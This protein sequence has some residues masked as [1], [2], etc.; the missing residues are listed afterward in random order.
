[1]S[2]VVALTSA[3]QPCP[4]ADFTSKRFRA[5]ILSVRG[6]PVNDTSFAAITTAL[7]AVSIQYDVY[8]LVNDMKQ[9]TYFGEFQLYDYDGIGKYSAIIMTSY[10]MTYLDQSGFVKQALTELQLA[11]IRE[12][13]QNTSTRI[14]MIGSKLGPDNIIPGV[15]PRATTSLADSAGVLAM[16]KLGRFHSIAF[17][18]KPIWTTSKTIYIGSPNDNVIPFAALLRNTRMDDD[19]AAVVYNR[20][21][22]FA[23]GELH[24][25][26]SGDELIPSLTSAAI[27]WAYKGLGVTYSAS[28]GYVGL[29]V[30]QCHGVPIGVQV[31][32]PWDC[33]LDINGSL[34]PHTSTN[35]ITVH[36][37]PQII[38]VTAITSETDPRMDM[39]ADNVYISGDH[40]TGGGDSE[41]RVALT[42]VVV[43]RD[44][45]NNE[46]F[47]EMPPPVIIDL[48]PNSNSSVLRTEIMDGFTYVDY[49]VNNPGEFVMVISVGQHVT[50][51]R[52]KTY[53]MTFTGNVSL[54]NEP[55]PNITLDETRPQ[56]VPDTT[57]NCLRSDMKILIISATGNR[58]LDPMYAV[59]VDNLKSIGINYDEISMFDANFQSKY[60]SLP[61]ESNGRA[62]YYAIILSHLFLAYREPGQYSNFEQGWKAGATNEQWNQLYAYAKKYN[63]RVLALSAG[64][65]Y[66][67]VPGVEITG[68]TNMDMMVSL[69]DAGKYY[70]NSTEITAEAPTE[71][72]YSVKAKITDL[73]IA[74]EFMKFS[75]PNAKTYIGPAAVIVDMPQGG[76]HLL[77]MFNN[78]PWMKC[79]RMFFRVF[80]SWLTDGVYIAQ[81]F[82]DDKCSYSA[83]LETSCTTGTT[84]FLITSTDICYL[85][86]YGTE[87][88]IGLYHQIELG[89]KTSSKTIH[90]KRCTSPRYPS[91]PADVCGVCGG[92]GICTCDGMLLDQDSDAYVIDDVCY[93]EAILPGTTCTVSCAG[94]WGSNGGYNKMTCQ[95][96]GQLAAPSLLCTAPTCNGFSV[97]T[98]P[99]TYISQG[100]ETEHDAW[101]STCT[102]SCMHGYIPEGQSTGIVKCLS[103]VYTASDFTCKSELGAD[104]VSI[105]VIASAILLPLAAIGMGIAGYSAY[106]KRRSQQ[107]AD[108]VDEH[109]PTSDDEMNQVA[110][111]PTDPPLDGDDQTRDDQPEPDPDEQPS[112]GAP[113]A[114]R[115][116]A[117]LPNTDE[118]PQATPNSS[119]N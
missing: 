33:T 25:F 98:P 20:K 71:K 31:T 11:Q 101:R 106:K 15:S 24:L 29:E 90:M 51:T 69:A 64:L 119:R 39:C 73:S 83:E 37:T 57:V 111:P 70:A 74:Q 50:D 89:I 42:L 26:L 62:K 109:F 54:Y 27:N 28:C 55:A 116:Q 76:K 35:I 65:V 46:I 114:G 93:K 34:G 43:A 104:R 40:M 92:V 96:N 88:S 72:E 6:D 105:G 4:I 53:S 85:K 87:P 47:D 80:L 58:A 75:D 3:M 113:S 21:L 86:I 99:G 30:Q 78:G 41:I 107:T 14:I 10:P 60:T 52:V 13:A 59:A 91:G 108:D 32:T 112:A 49:T 84:K 97:R 95:G 117:V 61:L 7:D 44:K 79:S 18:R 36:N 77:S 1:M 118:V 94:G 12:Y 100:C 115:T 2:V 17:S 19:A 16:T 81:Q 82:A 45:K 22:P 9:K 103:N 63:V 68:S 23:V 5:F 8:K 110:V 66:N 67:S 38:S 56:Q 102:L 48:Q